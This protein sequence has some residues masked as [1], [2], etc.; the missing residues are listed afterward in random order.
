MKKY[1]NLFPFALIILMGISIYSMI[2]GAI[3]QQNQLEDLLEE[4]QNCTE[5]ELYDKAASYYNDI[6]SIDDNIDYYLLAADMYYD[7]GEY[8]ASEKW[9][10][11]IIES[12]PKDVRGY[13]YMIRVCL[14]QESYSDAYSTLSNFDG[15][16]LYSETIENY[17]S[18]M[19]FLY[20]MDSVSF[21][22]V[23]QYSS[24]YVGIQ[25][26][27]LWG[28][29][30][31]KGTNKVK[32]QFEQIGYF[33]NDIIAV[34]D[35]EKNWY[36]ID[37]TGEYLYNISKSISGTITD[38]GLY[39]NDLFPVCTDGVYSYYNINFEK[40]FGEYDYAG[41]FSRGVAAVKK[42]NKWQIIDTSGTS[43]TED[44]Y[45]DV[46][47]DDRGICCQKDRIFVKI[48]DDEYI[49]INSSGERIGS[50]SFNGAKLF[51]NDEYA[52]I[53]KDKLWGFINLSGETVITPTY[54]D[55]KSFSLGLA[56]VCSDGLWGYVDFSGNKIIDFQYIDCLN[57]SSSGTAFVQTENNWAIISLYRY[58]Y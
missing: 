38:V 56:A 55:A 13:E 1:R 32:P 44:E 22:F 5:Q 35:S 11:K 42:D 6:I 58:K 9:C 20:Y 2:S 28:L 39:N 47:L 33:A 25:K 52:A 36:F 16:N 15:R 48:S 49:M 51:S 26:K 53:L 24:D 29:A 7:A 23:T 54:E 46:I 40:Q 12:F 50:E 18:E 19:E 30:T 14:Q 31:V 17:R 27:G 41:S 10:E 37:E 57:F 43:I 45:L 4:A 8:E 3:S 21:D 34:L